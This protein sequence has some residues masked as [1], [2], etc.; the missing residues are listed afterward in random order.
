M[1]IVVKPRSRIL[2]GVHAE[3]TLSTVV[4]QVT[5]LVMLHLRTQTAFKRI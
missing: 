4:E 3:Q 5:Q 2:A 1:V